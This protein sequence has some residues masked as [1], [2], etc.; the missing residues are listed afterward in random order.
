M[1]KQFDTIDFKIQPAGTLKLH[2]SDS[3]RCVLLLNGE[4]II[5]IIGKMERKYFKDLPKNHAKEYHYL[6]P[7]ELYGYLKEAQRLGEDGIAY[8]LSCSCDEVGCASASMR[9]IETENSIIWKGFRTIRKQIFD[10][11]YEFDIGEYDAFLQK[12]KNTPD[13]WQ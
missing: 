11:S 8:I 9:I 12:L 6:P 4:D 13:N 5:E 3:D 10:L 1:N 2:W 7:S